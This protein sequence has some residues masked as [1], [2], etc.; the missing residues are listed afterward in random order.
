MKNGEISKKDLALWI[1]VTKTTDKIFKNKEKKTILQK[2]PINK[3]SF[4]KTK[5]TLLQER[6]KSAVLQPIDLRISDKKFG[7]EKSTIKNLKRG[8]YKNDGKT[9]LHGM[10]LYTAEKH[11]TNFILDQYEKEN[12]NLLVVSGKG[13][14]GQG[15]IRQEIPI[16]FGKKPLIDIVYAYT[17]ALQKDGGEGAFYIRLR[18]KNKF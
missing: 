16:W 9:D 3:E 11:L 6:K 4:S 7:L 14:Y 5:E 10:N 1:E 17:N 2:T 13:V 15:K 8:R 18:K 12:R